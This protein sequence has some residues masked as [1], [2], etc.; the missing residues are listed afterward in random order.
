MTDSG[1]ATDRPDRIADPARPDPAPVDG[2]DHVGRGPRGSA[3]VSVTRWRP[4]LPSR[5]SVRISV[6]LGVLLGV[7]YVALLL[8][9]F[10]DGTNGAFDPE[11]YDQVPPVGGV[12]VSLTTRAVDPNAQTMTVQ[13]RVELDR[14]LERNGYEAGLGSQEPNRPLTVSLLSQNK[15]EEVDQLDFAY[16][17]GQA[18]TTRTVTL[19]FTGYIRGWPFDRYRSQLVVFVSSGDTA[20]PVDVSLS[21]QVQNWSLAATNL[22]SP[23]AVNSSASQ[24]KARLFDLEFRRSLGTILFGLAV[25]AVLITLPVLG[26]FVALAVYRGRRRLEPAFLGWIAALLFATVPLR[27]FLP[28]SPPTGSWV[29][30]AV[31]LWVLVGLAVALVFVVRVW[32][33]DTEPPAPTADERPDR[34]S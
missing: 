3:D 9:Y 5:R 27:N 4:R 18:A 23:D 33:R 30:V 16:P 17:A 21:G 26:L 32:W 19:L 20:V 13:M 2:A 8:A 29:D 31:V 22:G 7:L 11:H 15:S 24:V 1:S 34:T 25:V 12:L 28:G 14:S 6:A 10:R